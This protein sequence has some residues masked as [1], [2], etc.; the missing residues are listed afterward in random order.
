MREECDY[1]YDKW[2]MH[3][4]NYNTSYRDR[5]TFEVI[6]SSKDMGSFIEQIL[7]I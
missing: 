2:Y 1:D 7:N 3:V 5:K 4:V 6:I